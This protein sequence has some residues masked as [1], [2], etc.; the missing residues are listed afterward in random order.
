MEVLLLDMLN[1]RVVQPCLIGFLKCRATPSPGLENTVA[2]Q[3]EL[4]C[5]SC[6][7]LSVVRVTKQALRL[8]PGSNTARGSCVTG[9]KINMPQDNEERP[10]ALC[11][12][13]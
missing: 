7:P 13:I 9:E 10:S 2:D 12:E 1:M 5:P 11:K 6:S 8:L 4:L 3:C